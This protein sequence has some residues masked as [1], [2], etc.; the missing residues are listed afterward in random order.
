MIRLH[1]LPEARHR[2]PFCRTKL[3]ILGWYIPGMRNLADL[4]CAQCRRE[5]YGDLTAGQAFYTPMLL[6]K[7]TGAVHDPHGV[8]WFAGWLRESY[9]GRTTTPL[10][11]NVEVRSTHSSQAVLLN[12]ID[13]LYGHALLKL[14]NAQ[15]YLDH[16]PGLDLILLIPSFLRWLVPDGVAQVW[17]VDLPLGRGTQWNDWLAREVKRH[18]EVY[19]TAYLS[20]A[21]SH[22]HPLDYHIERFTRITPFPLDE[23]AMRL[24]RSTVTFIWRED[25]LWDD[26]HSARR[27]G[28]IRRLFG[29]EV[30]PLNEQQRR[31]IAFAEA[32]RVESPAL[33]F[34]VA[35]LG[36][37]RG[38][39]PG[40]IEDL[41]QDEIDSEIERRWCERYA[42]SHLVVGVHGSNM[43]LP[44]AHAG[45]IVEL[46][47][48]HR[49]GNFLQDI[50][51]RTG[52]T[53][54]M[55]FRYRFLPQS[56]TPETLSQL[57]S[58][59]L[60]GYPNFQYLMNPKR[61]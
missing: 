28:K 33:D 16:H 22:P 14:L 52:D 3:Q 6:E 57:S 9:A 10:Q 44:S 47:G 11:F 36:N 50:L 55:F 58:L 45:S 32:L 17:T 30:E 2:C 61:P 54:E 41:R 49:W 59:M 37:R 19:E 46:I 43:L 25:R 39:L 56:T 18:V 23:W 4:R 53:R 27:A 31:I 12:C 15:Y 42:A 34:A 24:A 1:P 48:P 20:V 7:E 21:F 60:R 51:L 38:G 5:F 40:W 8:E 29:T 35:G 26:A 13:T